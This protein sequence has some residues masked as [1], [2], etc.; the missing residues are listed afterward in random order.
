MSRRLQFIIWFALIG[1][2]LLWAA[3]LLGLAYP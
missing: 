2:T 1:G 3:M